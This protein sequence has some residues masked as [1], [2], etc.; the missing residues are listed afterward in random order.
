MN[1]ILIYIRGFFLGFLIGITLGNKL[2]ENA[3]KESK[4]DGAD[5]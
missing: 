5:H 4:N 3:F 1:S 2:T